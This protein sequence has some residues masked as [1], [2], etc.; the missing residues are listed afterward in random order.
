MPGLLAASP[1]AE[2]SERRR[3][4]LRWGETDARRESAAWLGRHGAADS[5]PALVDALRDPDQG[6]RLLSENAIWRIWMRS[7]DDGVD[8]RLR[9]GSEYLNEHR[10]QEALEVFDE[11]V[12]M[13]PEFAEGYN[14]RATALY[15]LGEYERSMA[16]IRETLGRNPFHFGALSGA[17]LCM[18]AL[19]EPALALHYFERALAINPNLANVKEVVEKLR[20][21]THERMM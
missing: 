15:Y 12:R 19:R 9:I 7:G 8:H 1:E 18:M 5:V 11:V 20:R 16:D 17:G 10:F 14:K 3:E 6:V 21:I 13:A 4:A 2:Q